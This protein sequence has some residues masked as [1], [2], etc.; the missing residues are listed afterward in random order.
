MSAYASRRRHSYITNIF[1]CGKRVLHTRTLEEL[2]LLASAGVGIG[3][4]PSS[5]PKYLRPDLCSV[6]I[7]GPQWSFSFLLISRRE[8]S[9]ASV[10]A[11]FELA[12]HL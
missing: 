5:V 10:R 9:R 11:M 8:R 12:E 6:P 7:D 4:L 3:L 2:F 1:K